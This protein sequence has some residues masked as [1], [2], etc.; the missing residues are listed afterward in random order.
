MRGEPAITKNVAL[1]IG[2]NQSVLNKRMNGK[3]GIKQLA[4]VLLNPRTG[5]K[6]G[7]E[8]SRTVRLILSD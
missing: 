3:G 2:R 1:T 5:S 4:S 7:P 8:N 6:S